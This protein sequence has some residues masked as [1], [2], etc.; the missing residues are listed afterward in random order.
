MNTDPAVLRTLFDAAPEG[1]MVCDAI[2]ADM[3]IIYVNRAMEQLTGYNREEMHGRNPRFLYAADRDQDGIKRMRAALAEGNGCHVTVRNFRRDGTLF[4]N[5]LNLV[6]LRDE[7][8]RLTHYASFHREPAGPL[9]AASGEFKDA[10][11]S[12]Q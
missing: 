6:P 2:A 7:Q 12:T 11:L 5:D 1:V 4:F 9:R 8:G 10:M 3:P